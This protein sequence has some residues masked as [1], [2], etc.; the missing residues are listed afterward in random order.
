MWSLAVSYADTSFIASDIEQGQVNTPAVTLDDG[1]ASGGHSVQFRAAE[2]GGGDGSGTVNVSNSA[3][4]SMALANAKTGDVIHLADGNYTGSAR[5]GNYTGSFVLTRSGTASEPITLIGSRNAV[6][7]GDG[8][9]GHYGLY[10][11]G[12]SYWYITGITVTNATKGIVLDGGNHVTLSDVRVYSIGQE[13]VHFRAFSSDNVIKNSVVEQTGV[14]QAQYGEGVYIGSANSNWSTYSGGQPDKSDRNKV[15]NNIIGNTGAENIDIKEGSTGGLID[16]N[17]FD[18][19]HIQGENSADSWMDVKGNSYTITNNVAVVSSS[20]NTV[21][22]NG[23]ELHQA[24][25]GWGINNVFHKNTMNL[26]NSTGGS[27]K[28]TGFG[29]YQQKGLN[30]NILSCDNMVQNA[31]Q[32]FGV[33]NVSAQACN[34]Q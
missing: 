7:D 3:Q 21:F 4:L 11:V 19:V 20:A 6:I 28:T 8:L 30:G 2:L 26:T 13:G 5:V 1:S 14:K 9:G 10:V 32:G 16:G 18:G 23:F 17:R 12:A 15:L 22:N 29:F 25:A 34:D 31:P 27:D 33:Y 24:V